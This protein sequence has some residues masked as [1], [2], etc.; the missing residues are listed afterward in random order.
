MST[1]DIDQEK[2]QPKFDELISLSEAAKISGLS[3]DHLRRL[4]GSG[5]IWAEKIGRNWATTEQAV[6]DYLSRDRRSGPKKRD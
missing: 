6:R 1:N 5:D 4:A 3:H 2:D